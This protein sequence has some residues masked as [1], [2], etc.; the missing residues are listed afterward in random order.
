MKQIKKKPR[1]STHYVVHFDHDDYLAE[2]D[3]GDLVMTNSYAEA[4]RFATP[5]EAIDCAK[6]IFR[7]YPTDEIGL[8]LAVYQVTT[9]RR[10]ALLT[11]L[12]RI[13]VIPF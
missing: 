2:I 11:S 1:T 12:R 10:N 8:M 4:K 3:N 6:E 9:G 7:D 5:H 13:R